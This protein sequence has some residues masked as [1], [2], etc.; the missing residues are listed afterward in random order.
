MPQADASGTR[1]RVACAALVAAS[2]LALAA[3]GCGSSSDLSTTASAQTKRAGGTVHVVMQDL[4]FS[5]TVVHASVGQS[6][7]WTNEDPV[8]HN[9]T[10]ISGPKFSSSRPEMKRFL[11]YELRLTEPGTIRYYCTI[12]PWMKASI[13]VSP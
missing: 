13:V 3:T 10:Y 5:P 8:P 4:A 2:L 11:T 1:R 7:V 9:V 12:H 6:V